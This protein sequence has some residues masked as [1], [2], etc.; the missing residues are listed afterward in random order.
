MLQ[1]LL[2]EQDRYYDGVLRD[3]YAKGEERSVDEVLQRVARGLAEAEAPERRA[4]WQAQFLNALKAG[5][6]PAGRI[7]SAAGTDLQATLINCFVQPV[8]DSIAQSRDGKVGIYTALLQAAETMRR[9]GGVGYDFSSI[10]PRGAKVHGT[11]SRASG[12]I[13][14]MRVFDRSCETVESAGARRGAQMGILRVDHPD[15][16]AFIAAKDL[17]EPARQLA[18]AGYSGS[19]LEALLQKQRTLANFNLSVA[20]SDAF[21]AA[22]DRD[23]DIELAHAAEPDPSEH[24]EAY[25]RADGLWVYRRV[26]AA[27][28]WDALL[29][30]TYETAD[31]GVV[32]IDRMNAENNLAYC[33][34]IEAT[35]PCITADSWVH[36]DEGPRQ[37]REL[38]GRA[39]V[40]RVDGESHAA[41]ARGFFVTGHKPVLNLRTEEGYRLRLTADHP[42]LSLRWMGRWTQEPVW[43][44]AGELLPGELIVLHDH[45][46]QPQWPGVESQEEGYLLGLLLAE[47]QLW[48]EAAVLS[49][50]ARP[51][52]VGGSPAQDGARGVMTEALRC[53]ATLAPGAPLPDW[54]PQ[55]GRGEWRLSLPVLADLAQRMGLGEGQ[56]RVTPAMERAS[57][58]FYCGLLRGLFDSAGQVQACASK[59]ASLRLNLADYG[60]AEAVQRMLLRL[61]MVSS[62]H[63]DRRHW[64]LVLSGDNLAI[65]AERIGFADGEKAARLS[66]RL[67]GYKRGLN[68]SRFAA[69][70]A[71]IEA[72][73]AE[74]VYDCQIPGINAFDAN[75]LY[76]HNCGEQPLPD[77][78]CCCLGSLNLALFVSEPFTEQARLDWPRLKQTAA[79]A[80]RMLDN[81]LDLTHWPLPEQQREAMNKRRVGLG[82]TG[83]GTALMMLRQRYGSEEAVQLTAEI[84]RTLRDSAYEASVA[85]AQERGAFPL[86]D[87]DHYLKSPFVQRLP[88]PLRAAIAQ[89][90]LRNSHLLSIAP[91]GT[92]SLAFG[93]NVTGGIEPAFAWEYHRRSRNRD[94]EAIEYPIQDYGYRL[95]L[96]M[97]GDAQNLPGYFASAQTLSPADHL[98][99]QAAVQPYIDSSISKTVNVPV[100]CGFEEFKRIYDLAYEWGCKGCTT[101][102][103]NDITGA[104][105]SVSPAPGADARNPTL[106]LPAA[107]LD[108]RLRLESLPSP[109]LASLK[110][111]GRPEFAAGNPAWTYMVDAGPGC[112][113]A[114]FVGHTANG[115]SRPFEVW[116]N[117]AEQPRG[118]GATAKLLSMDMRSDDRAWLQLKLEALVRTQGNPVQVRMPP[119][120]EPQ[121]LASPTAALA[122]LVLHRCQELGVFAEPGPTPVVD[123]LLSREEPLTGTDGTMSWTVDVKNA[124]TGDDC[125]LVLRELQLPD[126]ERRPYAVGLYGDYPKDLDGLCRLLSYDMR[127]L[128]PAWIGEKLRKLLSYPETGGGFFARV[129]GKAKSQIYP[130]TVAYLAELMLHRYHMLGILNAEGLPQTPLG[131]LAAPSSSG[132]ARSPAL[133]GKPCPECGVHAV[134]KRDGCQSCTHCGWVG[135]CG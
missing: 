126:G 101:Y 120:G 14:Y 51:L 6:Y 26:K 85:L 122:R 76:V 80:V 67:A 31:P 115:H 48:S 47:G 81:V 109:P 93:R 90:G 134:V 114:V 119:A 53:V 111:P 9:G 56:T 30:T 24:P 62:L 57:S 129:P 118:L 1:D 70:V 41:T 33:E 86:F 106:E 22:K 10:R 75:G 69:R 2:T 128:D 3:K 91:T 40:A 7:M 25:Q 124:N 65:Y 39:F 49:L 38:L 127:V 78:G 29:R 68:R 23:E 13:S 102:R 4:H 103:P 95:Y 89:H 107:S 116:V 50:W 8:G 45:R 17:R 52:A 71:S 16:E 112:R 117:G 18:A 100:E 132:S 19:E 99:I 20:V 79:T 131:V 36:T 43:K 72:G 98:R 5:F 58:R 44:K 28:L 15:I 12:P 113:F 73:P 66:Q 64:E 87:A 59:G 82:F 61:G 121:L 35:N 60:Q 11:R 32:F 21:M 94:G 125:V 77:Y 27:A 97:G 54:R 96:R 42:V 133:P 105:L 130:S 46:D 34:R 84:A 88:E 63:R 123:A 92:I 110:W 104:V 108:Q 74:T 83:L 37:V 55:T 135:N